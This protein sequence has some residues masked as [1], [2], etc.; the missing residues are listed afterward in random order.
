[1]IGPAYGNRDHGFFI[2]LDRDSRLSPKLFEDDKTERPAAKRVKGMDD[3][4]V[5]LIA[6]ITCS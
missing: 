2:K 4:N 1:M 6:R 5:S 3:P